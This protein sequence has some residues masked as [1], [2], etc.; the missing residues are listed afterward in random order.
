MGSEQMDYA[1]ILAN[2]E[3]KRAAL[4]AT[5]ASI[6]A[7]IAT[8]VLGQVGDI[9]PSA[10]G[11]GGLYS[12]MGGSGE[13]PAGAFLGKSIPDAAKL[14]LEI[15]KKKQTSK[16]IA[17]ALI[18]GGM[19]S[20]SRNFQQ[21][22]HSILDRTRKANGGIVKLDRSYWGLVTWYP[23]GLLRASGSASEKR[24]AL[25]K[26]MKKAKAVKAG[27]GGG[28]VGPQQ[29]ASTQPPAQPTSAAGIDARVT[30]FLRA[31]DPAGFS[32]KQVA[33]ALA[34]AVGVVNFAAARL[35]NRGVIRRG[36]DGKLYFAKERE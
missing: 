17:E 28:V 25:R 31:H 15:V 34:A 2:L 16:E 1:V 10:N 9:P 23:A 36:D 6:R 26:K 5:I 30:N 32:A 35:A 12:P 29:S 7:A 3:A 18:K 11:G 14:Y 13:I 21:I 8:G 22:V 33:E 27:K 19:E 20:S 4:D 24:P